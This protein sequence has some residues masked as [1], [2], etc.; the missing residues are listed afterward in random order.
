MHIRYLTAGES[1]GKALVAIIDGV[2]KGIALD[3]AFINKEL[4]RRMSGFGRGKRMSIEK[5]KIEVLS[6]TRKGTTLGSP[7]ALL[8]KNRDHKIE[9]LHSIFSPRPGHADLAGAM[10]FGTH[11]MRDILER[12]SARE[13]ASR[14]AIGAVMKL[15]LRVFGIEVLSHVRQIGGITAGSC[16]PFGKIRTL[17]E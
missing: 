9:S 16:H 13:T 8:V 6:G 11:D 12:S 1:H 14:V 3:T 15:I 5:D 10:K 17:S 4:K 2:P 7:I